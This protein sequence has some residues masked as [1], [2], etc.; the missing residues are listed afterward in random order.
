MPRFLDREESPENYREDNVK[1]YRA[2]VFIYPVGDK[3]SKARNIEIAHGN[4][5]AD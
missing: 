2:G 3:G 5:N 1:G 4:S